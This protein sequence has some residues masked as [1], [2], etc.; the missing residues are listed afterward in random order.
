MLA[1]VRVIYKKK[2]DFVHLWPK[3]CILKQ[4]EGKIKQGISIPRPLGFPEIDDW[5]LKGRCK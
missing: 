5:L 2:Y 3:S 4:R 1:L